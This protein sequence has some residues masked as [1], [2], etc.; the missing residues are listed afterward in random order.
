LKITFVLLWSKGAKILASSTF[1][2]HLLMADPGSCEFR[3]HSWLSGYID[4]AVL[5]DLKAAL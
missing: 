1:T 3:E 5:E 2:Y 4:K